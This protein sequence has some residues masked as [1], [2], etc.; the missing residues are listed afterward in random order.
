[1]A[2][3]AALRHCHHHQA[4]VARSTLEAVRVAEV[5][6]AAAAMTAP[7]QSLAAVSTHP[8]LLEAG[9]STA[10]PV[11]GRSTAAPVAEPFPTAVQTA[12]PTAAAEVLGVLQCHPSARTRT[13]RRQGP[14][15]AASAA[16]LLRV[17][18]MAAMPP[19]LAAVRQR[20]AMPPGSAAVRLVLAAVDRGQGLR[21]RGR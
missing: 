16:V 6:T 14:A 7:T 3:A 8:A 15:L 11:A 17:R 12:R 4:A 2:V 20:A 21:T 18:Q 19:G 5:T 10:A 13:A 1:V 9:R